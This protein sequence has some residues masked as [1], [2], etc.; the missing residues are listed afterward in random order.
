MKRAI[1]TT[2][3]GAS[4]AL[5]AFAQTNAP[6]T[7]APSNGNLVQPL[8]FKLTAYNQN[9]SGNVKMVRITTKD[10]INY[11]NGG[12]VSGGQL[13]LVTPPGNAPGTTGDLNAFLRVV[14]GRN[15]IVEVPSPDSFN[16]FQDS[17]V[18]QGN[19]NHSTVHALNRFSIDFGQFHSE[20]AGFSSWNINSK[21]VGGVDTGG[22]GA[23]VSTVN[24]VATVDGVTASGVPAQGT[25]SAGAPK[26]G[27]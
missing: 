2:M 18:V 19:G 1:L 3:T 22:S 10:V 24:G 14:R 11:F 6:D 12:P 5:G 17:A 21:T 9:D 13:L 26:P 20:L 16:L 23:F 7:N 8:T 25:V 4:L 15:T 27:P